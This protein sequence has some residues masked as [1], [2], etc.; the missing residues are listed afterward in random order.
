[1]KTF[2]LE[3]YFPASKAG[4]IGKEICGIR[5]QTRESLYEYWERFKRLCASCLHHQIS[6]QLL[7]QYF[8]EGLF[9]LD[10]S[11]ID[12]AS[13]EAL[14]DKTPTAS[15]SLISNMATNSQQFGVRQ[16]VSVK[17]LNE[18]NSKVEQQ[19]A[20][21]TSMVQQMAL[22]H[23]VRPCGIC[24]LVGHPTD[25]CPTLQEDTNEHVNAMGGGGGFPGQPR[26]RYDPYAITYNEGW[27][28]HPNL[29]YG[30]KQQTVPTRPPGF[31]SQQRPQQAYVTC[32]QQLPTGVPQ[33]QEPSMSDML[34]T[35]VASNIQTQV[36]LQSTQVSLKNLENTIGQIAT[37]L[38]KLET[39]N[40]ERLPP[41]LERNPRANVSAITLQSEL[42]KFKKEEADNEIL[43]TFRK[44]EAN[45]PL[46]DAIKQVPRYAKFFKDLCTNKKKLKGNEK[47][48]V[49]ENVSA[50]LQK[51]LPPKCKDPG[52]FTIPCMIGNKR[53]ERC[54]IDLGASINVMSYST[55]ASLNL[56]PLKE[57]RV[58][59]QLADHTNAYPLGVVEDVLVKVDG[60][61]FPVDFYILEM[62]DASIPNPTLVLFGRP[63]LMTTNTKLDVRARTLTME[64]DSMCLILLVRSRGRRLH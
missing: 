57:T 41:Q 27:K 58:I 64:F 48:S 7:I 18:T 25:A 3:R 51:K 38:S 21:L 13:G 9:P 50:V 4:S 54:M 39:Q 60:L 42:K 19:L 43:E 5:Q 14:V 56:G 11:M 15:R 47:R 36:I 40:Y 63:F 20:Q 46:L 44:V 62:G 34:K 30:N 55:Y 2:F 10:R 61:V 49:G 52:T 16:E 59:I 29:R 6:E 37:S 31:N 33:A 22:G 12:A 45:I 35:L 23:Q 24:Q 8:Y 17:G 32:H 53:I 26:Q 28:E 1:M